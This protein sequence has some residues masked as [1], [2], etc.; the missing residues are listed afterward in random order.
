MLEQIHENVE[1]HPPVLVHANHDVID[2]SK[3]KR[4]SLSGEAGE[5]VQE[6]GLLS[7][8]LHFAKNWLSSALQFAHARRRG[9]R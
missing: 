5:S 6:L 3:Q 1:G 9:T 4:V 7:K 2:H 8:V